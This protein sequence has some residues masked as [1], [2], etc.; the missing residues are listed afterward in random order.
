PVKQLVSSVVVAYPDVEQSVI[1]GIDPGVLIAN[2]NPL[3]GTA[4]ADDIERSWPY[5]WAP[6]SFVGTWFGAMGW[7][8]QMLLFGTLGSI[9]GLT[10]RNLQQSRFRRI[11][12]LPLGFG[13]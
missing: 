9:V 8:A 1:W 11:S 6:L 13:V 2:A 7:A 4:Q 10:M 5:Q 3:P 12:F